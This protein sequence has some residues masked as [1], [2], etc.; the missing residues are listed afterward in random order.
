MA[1]LTNTLTSYDVGSDGGNREELADRIFDISPEETP[2]LSM[3]GKENVKTTHPEWLIDTLEEG[4]VDNAYPQGDEFEYDAIEVPTRVGNYTQIS[5]E[6]FIV[7]NT[8]EQ[9]DTAGRKSEIARELRRKGLKLRF[10]MEGIC[11][12]N[13]ASV[14]GDNVT[15]GKMGGMPAWLTSNALRGSGGTDGGFNTSTK[16]VDVAGNGTQRAFSKSL[17]DTL[18]QT[19]HGSGGNIKNLMVSD[20][21]KTVFST[22]INDSNTAELRRNMS[23]TGQATITAAADV[24]VS[25][26]GP[27]TVMPNRRMTKLG[28]TIARN[29]FMVDP[30][31]VKLGVYRPIQQKKPAIT[32][33]AEKRVLITEYT[34]CV[35]NEAAHGVIADLYGMTASS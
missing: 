33:D 11:L 7:S 6:S 13:Q 8:Q 18:C 5:R 21:V 9:N 2:F 19:V 25:D 27:V 29:A 32:G 10:S 16:V 22:I 4:D 15:P 30:A 24:Y 20:Y 14:A 1:S 31:Y 26:F 23:G 17:L 12:S 3:I 28:A 35:K 34:L